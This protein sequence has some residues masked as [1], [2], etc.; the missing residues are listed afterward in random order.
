MTD[1]AH[2]RI[3]AL[4]LSVCLPAMAGCQ[5]G[6]DIKDQIRYTPGGPIDVSANVRYIT[7][8]SL[9]GDLQAANRQAICEFFA[10]VFAR[11]SCEGGRG[12]RDLELVWKSAPDLLTAELLDAKTGQT[13]QSRRFEK[14]ASTAYTSFVARALSEMAEQLVTSSRQGPLAAWLAQKGGVTAA[15]PPPARPPAPAPVAIPVPASVSFGRYHALVVGNQAYRHLPRLRTPIADAQALAALLRSD[16]GFAGVTV[17][18]DATRLDMVRALDELRRTLTEQDNL[19]VYYAGHGYLDKDADRGYWLPVDA[20]TDDTGNWLSTSDIVDKL[21]AMRA[22][23]VLV[24]ADSCFSG[25][26]VRDVAIRPLTAPDLAR[27]TQKRAR[28]AVTSGGLEPVS[29]TGGGDHSVFAKA[30]LDVLRGVEDATDM[31]TLFGALRRQV[32]LNAQQTPQYSDVRQ[33]GHDGGDFVF[34]RRR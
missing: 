15:P 10:N 22:K 33:A 24:V 29:D 18:T 20:G 12:G 5:T 27:L 26:L 17:L 4:V 13:L 1:S 32:L 30:F 16:Y 28:T 8:G 19:L 7:H 31:T 25:T 34:V 14:G 6:T 11:A 21:R 9:R 3:A 2:R 23:H